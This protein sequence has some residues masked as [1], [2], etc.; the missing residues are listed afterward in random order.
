MINAQE[1]QGKTLA[2]LKAIAERV[3]LKPHHLMKEDGLTKLILGAQPQTPPQVDPM[4][5]PAVATPTKPKHDNTPESI[6]EAI[7]KYT[8]NPAFKARFNTDENTWHF[9]CKGASECGNMAIP[10][11][12]IVAKAEFVSK[13]ARKIFA[14]EKPA[15]GGN[16]SDAVLAV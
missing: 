15:E 13:G 3:G 14:R 12:V 9:E 7:K 16:Y 1:L 4:K 11:R 2:E 10:I 6:L 8:E 5:H